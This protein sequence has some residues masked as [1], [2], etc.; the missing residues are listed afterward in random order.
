MLDRLGVKDFARIAQLSAEEAFRL[1]QRKHSN[2]SQ[3][4]WARFEMQVN[5]RTAEIDQRHNDELHALSARNKE[6]ESAAKLSEQQKSRE[7]EHANRRVEDCLRE[8]AAVRE[9]NQVLELDLSK[10][11]RV[12]KKE[13]LSFSEEVMTWPGVCISEKLARNGDYLLSFRDPSGTALE[14]R[15][16][17]DNKD[18]STIIEGDIKKLIRDARERHAPIAV[19]VARDENQLRQG[20][21]ECRWSQEDKVWVLRTTRSWFRRDLDVLRPFIE[22]IRT[23]GADFLQKNSALADEVRRTLVDLDAVENELKKATRAIDAAS[24]LTTRYRIRLQ[25]LCDS[26]G[27]QKKLPERHQVG[28]DSTIASA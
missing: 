7:I 10:V 12:G 2:D 23:E 4:V 14:P 21:R 25:A 1:L 9:R 20:D 24:G 18:K 26:S 22:H 13:E 3:N 11:A 19:I 6:L 8:L 15:L 5:Q 16:L 17:V 28:G 27:T